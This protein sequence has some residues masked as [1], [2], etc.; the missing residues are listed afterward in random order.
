ML[1]KLV[2]FICP[3]EDQCSTCGREHC[4]GGRVI[5]STL[6]WIAR[7]DF[8]PFL[9]EIKPQIC[10][11][12][13]SLEATGQTHTTTTWRGEFLQKL[14]P[15]DLELF[16]SI[17]FQLRPPFLESIG[18]HHATEFSFQGAVTLPWIKFTTVHAPI[19]GNPCEVGEV[20]IHPSHHALVSSSMLSLL[21]L[22]QGV[23]FVWYWSSLTEAPAPCT[24]GSSGRRCLRPQDFQR[25][26][27][28]R[29]KHKES[30]PKRIVG[31]PKNA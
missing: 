25:Q 13:L 14:G 18:P 31:Q 16:E 7:Q 4:T 26:P 19:P 27:E 9:L 2:K 3:C 5:F 17:Q 15:V 12:H 1:D 23:S 24:T 6:I 29:A 28:Q 8:L 10:D 22:K 11:S 20:H 30:V 21:L